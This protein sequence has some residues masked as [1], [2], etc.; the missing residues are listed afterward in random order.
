[1]TYIS[2]LL[3]KMSQSKKKIHSTPQHQLHECLNI[4]ELHYIC[5]CHIQ[6]PNLLW[7][8]YFFYPIYLVTFICVFRFIFIF[9]SDANTISIYIYIVYLCTNSKY[10]STT[11]RQ[12][13]INNIIMCG[14]WIL[15]LGI[16]KSSTTYVCT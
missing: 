1:M 5:L 4:H 16:W 9:C 7:I 3:S 12:N 11:Q 14:F 13:I 10:I 8:S 15:C 2:V 6:F